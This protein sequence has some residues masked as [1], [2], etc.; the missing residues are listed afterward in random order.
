LLC[1]ASTVFGEAKLKES[2]ETKTRIALWGYHIFLIFC[3][4]Y[5]LSSAIYS[6]E[7]MP[8]P[9]SPWVSTKTEIS[10]SKQET[11][12]SASDLLLLKDESK[13][14]KTLNYA[15]ALYYTVRGLNAYLGLGLVFSAVMIWWIIIKHIPLIDPKAL[16]TQDHH[17]KSSIKR[18]GL[19]LTLCSV[20]STV[21]ITMHGITL[22]LHAQSTPSQWRILFAESTWFI[23]VIFTIIGTA[24]AAKTILW[25]HDHL[26][27][28][29][30]NVER[31]ALEKISIGL[32]QAMAKISNYTEP[33]NILEVINISDK[34]WEARERIIGAM[35]NI[36]TWPLPAGA[37]M[38]F[39]LS[40]V[41]QVIDIIAAV[42]TLISFDKS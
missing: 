33:A 2:E 42:A 11:T 5:I 16:L 12:P 25:F 21:A 10:W 38:T 13:I 19:A 35:N 28:A 18:L 6:E 31:D 32:A 22:V 24:F 30:E 3:S 20:L 4:I 34:Y 39:A 36:P 23:W 40:L 27:T 7:I 26:V 15:G 14:S 37:G 17:I 1:T 8:S 41:L 29:I 9:A